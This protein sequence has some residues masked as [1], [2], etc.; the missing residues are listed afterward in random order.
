MT[1][2]ESV[3][4]AVDAEAR[5][6]KRLLLSYLLLLLI[7]IVIGGYAIARAPSQTEAVAHDVLPIVNEN[8]K[9][10]VAAQAEPIIRKELDVA[11][12]R[13]VKPLDDRTGKLERAMSERGGNP[14]VREL[15]D[16]VAKLEQQVAALQRMLQQRQPGISA[17]PV[18]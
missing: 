4:I 2:L 16:R 13:H 7:P 15:E 11:V 12:A 14:R 9:E 5:R 10:T 18:P 17:R 3:K 6:R 8:V 1:E